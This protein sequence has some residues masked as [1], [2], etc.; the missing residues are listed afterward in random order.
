MSPYLVNCGAIG[1]YDRSLKLVQSNEDDDENY[2]NKPGDSLE[3]STFTVPSNG[4]IA[5]R[6]ESSPR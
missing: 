2:Y 5:R 6:V 3:Y 4:K 1:Q